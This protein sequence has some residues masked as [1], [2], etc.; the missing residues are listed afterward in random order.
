MVELTRS[1]HD[2]DLVFA[3]L[4]DHS[5]RQMLTRLRQKSLSIS[6]LAAPFKMSFAGVAKHVEV[7]STAGLVRKVRAPEDGRSYRI[8]LENS[9]LA[10]AADWI[11]YHRQF[12]MNKLN[13]LEEFI[14]EEKDGNRNSKGRK[15]N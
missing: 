13:K 14:E 15:K 8:E 9:T 7:L 10:A 6:E 11:T 12:W 3:A 4:A 2:L 5:R 1:Q